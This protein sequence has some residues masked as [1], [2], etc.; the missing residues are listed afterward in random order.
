MIEEH[1][2]EVALDALHRALTVIVV[3]V[4]RAALGVDG[5]IVERQPRLSVALRQLQAVLPGLLRPPPVRKHL[6][7]RTPARARR[8][9]PPTHPRALLEQR[10][11]QHLR[12][13]RVQHASHDA[14]RGLVDVIRQ[15]AKDGERAARG[16]EANVTGL[17]FE[18]LMGSELQH[19][20]RG[21][22][23][24]R[25][26]RLG[27]RGGFGVE[28]DEFAMAV[29]GELEERV[30]A[31]RLARVLVKEGNLEEVAQG[32]FVVVREVDVHV[33][34]AL[35]HGVGAEVREDAIF[36]SLDHEELVHQHANLVV[37]DEKLLDELVR[38]RGGVVMRL[39]VQSLEVLALSRPRGGADVLDRERAE[40][41]DH[42]L[43]LRRHQEAAGERI[44]TAEGAERGA[45]K[46]L[47]H[48]RDRGRGRGAPRREDR[49]AT[50]R[51]PSCRDGTDERSGIFFVGRRIRAKFRVVDRERATTAGET[52]VLLC[53]TERKRGREAARSATRARRVVAS[54]S[55]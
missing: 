6:D 29:V 35:V 9:F 15:V 36:P 7:D 37:G 49:R 21:S 25:G 32:G 10:H 8:V 44:A 43:R 5:E 18:L 54:F 34:H 3:A 2:V 50:T 22:I 46:K 47:V 30:V 14:Q 24:R 19:L 16:A 13:V 4:P 26:E 17:V 53:V 48:R 45:G 23:L 1:F 52:S 28:V 12:V 38:V 31:R 20:V 51:A 41:L 55:R 40:L 11:E 42:A 39:D 27:V 33:G